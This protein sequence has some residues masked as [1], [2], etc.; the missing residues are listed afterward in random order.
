MMIT[1]L[2]HLQCTELALGVW[3]QDYRP[4]LNCYTDEWFAARPFAY[5]TSGVWG[6]GIPLVLVPFLLL[7]RSQTSAERFFRQ[8]SQASFGFRA[9][10]RIAAVWEVY[11]MLFRSFCLVIIAFFP[12]NGPYQG[13]AVLVVLGFNIVLLSSVQPHA[14]ALVQ[15]SDVMLQLSLMLI[16]GTGLLAV[17]APGTHTPDIIAVLFAGVAYAFVAIVSLIEFSFRKRIRK[18]LPGRRWSAMADASPDRAPIDI[19]IGDLH[20][21]STSSESDDPVMETIPETEELAPPQLGATRKSFSN[22]RQLSVRVIDTALLQMGAAVPPPGSGSARGQLD[23]STPGSSS[24]SHPSPG[25]TPAR[26]MPTPGSTRARP[27]APTP[28]PG[29]SRGRLAPTPTPRAPSNVPEFDGVLSPASDG[30][31]EPTPTR[32]AAGV[33]AKSIRILDGALTQ[34][35]AAVPPS[36]SPSKTPPR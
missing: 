9:D 29:S 4:D 30:M 32:R 13:S 15:L 33:R 22:K 14:T 35:G 31:D 19:S 16:V 24:V 8:T 1:A 36:P 23:S 20:A 21:E 6:L 18:I 12:G 17:A 26:L 5:V 25:S 3:R 34:M 7:R 27:D 10:S 28:T 11:S 2:E